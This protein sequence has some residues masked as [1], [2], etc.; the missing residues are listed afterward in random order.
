MSEEMAGITKCRTIENDKWGRKEQIKES[1]TGTIKDKI[2]IRLHMWEVHK[3]TTE[4]KVWTVDAQCVNQKREVK[5]NYGRKGLGSRCP[6]CQSEEDTAKDVLEC[7]KGDKK[8]NLNDER[9]KEWAE[10][11]EIYRKN[12]INR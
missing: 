5:P 3:L 11:I 8:F 10:I 7:N 2:K 1:R 6:M 9:A 12:N 4:G